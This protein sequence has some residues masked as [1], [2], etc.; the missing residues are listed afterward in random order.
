MKFVLG[1]KHWSSSDYCA[2]VVRANY[3]HEIWEDALAVALKKPNMQTQYIFE[4]SQLPLPIVQED[5]E[6][7]SVVTLV[8]HNKASE[9]IETLGDYTIASVIDT[10]PLDIQTSYAIST[11]TEPVWSICTLIA[12]IFVDKVF[13]PE[14]NYLIALLSGIVVDTENFSHPESTE[15][16]EEAYHRLKE[17]VN[18]EDLEGYI[19]DMLEKSS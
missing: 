17:L 1:S 11:R 18:I 16:D 9:S 7:W 15:R 13:I 4:K 8:N 3:Q 5:L 14:I 2:S 10:H 19:T 6:E 12:E